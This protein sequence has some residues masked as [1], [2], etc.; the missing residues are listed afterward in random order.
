MRELLRQTNAYC[1]IKGESERGGAPHATLVL[2]PDGTYL[3][4]L[5]KECAKAFFGAEDGDRVSRL[6]DEESYSDCLIFP[7]A[8]EKL[9]ADGAGELL[10]ESVL[11]SVEG[12]KKLFVLDA[13]QTV[14]P[15]V[16]NKLLKLLEEPCEGVYFLLGATAEYAVLPTVLSRMRKLEEP[17]FSEVQVEAALKRLHAGAVGIA[18]AAAAS[19]GVLSV[20]ES[21]LSDGDGVF[22]DA[23]RLLSEE[24]FVPVCREIAEKQDKRV[25]LAAFKLTV[26]DVLFYAAGQEKYAALSE[27]LRPLAEEYPAG[28]LLKALEFT[29]EAEKQIQFNANFAQALFTLCEKIRKEKIKWKKLS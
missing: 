2:F 21:L 29:G 25:F 20:A 26:R 24:D 16:Q 15:L 11:R 7:A 12:G 14:T 22:R 13:F 1:S 27:G 6:I 18:R 28:A 4:P 3:R 10:E 19:G 5:L 17:P 23:L 8:G 9:T